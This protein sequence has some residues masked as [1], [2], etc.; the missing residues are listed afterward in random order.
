M[1]HYQRRRSMRPI[2]IPDAFDYLARFSST[3]EWDPGVVRGRDGHAR[4]R[5]ARLGLPGGGD[6][7][8]AQGAPALRGH[9]VRP[10][11]HG[12]R[13][14]PRTARPSPRTRSP[15]RRPTAGPTDHDRG[16]RGPAPRSATTPTS[17]LKGPFRVLSP[18]LGL[19]FDRIGDRA[20]GGLR[21]ALLDRAESHADLSLRGR[22]RAR[23]PP[24]RRPGDA[25]RGRR[26]PRR[27]LHD[28][29]PLRPH[30]A[31]CPAARS[32]AEWRVDPRRPR[33]AGLRAG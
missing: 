20:A 2:A 19:L 16:R 27:A 15:S 7:R 23:R 1:A 30:R 10:A 13:C 24:D 4:A 22:R 14:G 31:G 6:V 18:V 12:A 28:R 26:A 32:G 3:A 21:A 17:Q 11:L 25:V 5:R 9:R 8:R 33:Q 29:L